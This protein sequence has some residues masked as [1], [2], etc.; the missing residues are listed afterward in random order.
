MKYMG[1][2]ARIA[3]YIVPIIQNKLQ[4]HKLNLYVEP[5]VGGGE[6]HR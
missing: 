1:S 2:K 4:E 3:K 6:Y 5:F